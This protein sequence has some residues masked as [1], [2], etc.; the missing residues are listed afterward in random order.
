MPDPSATTKTRRH[1]ERQPDS[2]C[3]CVF[4][5][6]SKCLAG[7]ACIPER[8]VWLLLGLALLTPINLHAETGYNAWLRYAALNDTQARQ[9]RTNLPAIVTALSD[10]A[11]EQSAQ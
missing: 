6:I 2:L 3:L 5:V 8:V 4:V 9:Y 1:K 11:L 10:D 7:G